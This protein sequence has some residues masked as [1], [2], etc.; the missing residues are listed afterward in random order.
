MSTLASNPVL[1]DRQKSFLF[2][3]GRSSLRQNFYAT[4]GTALAAFYLGHR[5]SEDLDLFCYEEF[6]AE[7]VLGFLRSIPSV[8]D[9]EYEH[10]FDRRLFLLRFGPSDVLKVEFTRYPFPR[11][12]AGIEIDNVRIDS[13]RDIIAN[14]LVAL[15]DR[16]DA[17]DY[18]DVYF[19]IRMK[20]DLDIEDLIRTAEQK[21]GFTGIK[22]IL[23]GR[24]LQDLPPTAG[25]RMCEPLDADDLAGFYHNKGRSWIAGSID[26]RT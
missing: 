23:R 19:A 17:K 15:T 22:H 6:T 12:D 14:K 11:C 18:V 2:H 10:K 21:F 16:R 13:L 5:I 1:T 9:I 7:T 8:E 20:P 3:F 4:G 24:F 25:L 26:D